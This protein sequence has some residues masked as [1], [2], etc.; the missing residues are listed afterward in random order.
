M[1]HGEDWLGE[2]VKDTVEDHL[3]VGGDDISTVGETPGD[4]VEKPEERED[5]GGGGECFLVGGTDDSGRSS[6]R[7]RENPP[8]VEDC[9]VSDEI[10][11][12]EGDGDSRATHPK[13]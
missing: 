5:K 11:M 2:D 13:V 1:N 12:G 6:S 10:Q 3:G 4:G 8:D 9:N 7:T